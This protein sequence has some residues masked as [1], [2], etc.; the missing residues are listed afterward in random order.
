MEDA[1]ATVQDPEIVWDRTI[2]GEIS[3]THDGGYL[4]VSAG[5]QPATAIDLDDGT[6]AWQA[7]DGRGVHV[8]GEETMYVG[9]QLGASGVQDGTHAIDRSTG[10]T[11][12]Q[13]DVDFPPVGQLGSVLILVDRVDG[14]LFGLDASDGESRWE[15]TA[16]AQLSR[17]TVSSTDDLY[18]GGQDGRVTAIDVET[19]EQRW[20]V[21]PELPSTWV[22]PNVVDGDDVYVGSHWGTVVKLDGETGEERWRNEVGNADIEG[23]PGTSGMYLED[24]L[25]V[26]SHSPT[27]IEALEPE[28]GETA[29]THELEG[30]P[31]GAVIDGEI[32]YLGAGDETVKAI[33]AEDGALEWQSDIRGRSGTP[34][35]V[36]G[37]LY[38]GSRTDQLYALDAETGD[39]YWSIETP[40]WVRR[41]PIVRDETII[42]SVRGFDHADG[43]VF[44]IG[45]ADE[46]TDES[47]ES[48]L[49]PV[50][51]AGGIGA[52]TLLGGYLFA[53]RRR[54]GD[55][56]ATAPDAESNGNSDE[57][58]ASSASESETT[59]SVP[60]LR[61]QA[62]TVRNAAEAAREKGD[63][64]ET[65]EAYD[66]ATD[67]YRAAL[68]DAG[69]EAADLR[70][71]I[72]DLRA[73]RRS[74]RQLVDQRE[75]LR[76]TLGVAE[77]SLHE[78][79]VAHVEGEGTLPRIRYRQARDAYD[80]ALELLGEADRDPLEAP[81]SVPIE[82]EGSHPP[83][84]VTNL[85]GASEREIEV[86]AK[87]GIETIDDLASD[88][89][90]PG[91]VADSEG[92]SEELIGRL[93]PL[94]WW[95][96]DGEVTFD[97]R[98][99]IERR[100]SHASTGLDAL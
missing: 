12:W 11:V 47:R 2:N 55:D 53:R 69:D 26:L 17:W 18:V 72:D 78:A 3:V 68:D 6:E 1:E 44:A 86:L 23:A 67:R 97:T 46:E 89:D 51:A 61:S 4:F 62:E 71:A 76:D 83:S 20:S 16:D 88:D 57:R 35:L 94:L 59:G 50:A 8:L 24:H 87:A 99:A 58:A 36:D 82:F 39:E 79:I 75:E 81:L 54:S 34:A 38:V 29:W 65:L 42:A 74:V 84:E 30:T 40:D 41:Q 52:A 49:V 85:P 66:R 9:G 73:E 21:D 96:G 80:D 10:E 27:Q 98:E 100:R 31:E 14:Q 19:G 90:L 22:D 92:L 37:R 5:E 64:E 33:D 95:Y 45:E 32:V 93:R 60:S 56:D 43:R 25:Y 48:S 7:T 28:T 15:F 91:S 13:V 63:F 70:V 77:R